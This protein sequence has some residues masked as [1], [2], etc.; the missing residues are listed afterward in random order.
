[1]A[2]RQNVQVYG[3][4]RPVAQDEV[5]DASLRPSTTFLSSVDDRDAASCFENFDSETGRLTY[6]RPDAAASTDSKS[7]TF[8]GLLGPGS[9]QE[10][11]YQGVPHNIVEGA[12]DGY[13]G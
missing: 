6:R 7:F 10:E 11:V 13:N 12:L 3:R 5:A 2:H 1:M 9:T 8:D 4:L